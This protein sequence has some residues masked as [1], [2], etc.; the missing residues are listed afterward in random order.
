MTCPTPLRI[1]KCLAHSKPSTPKFDIKWSFCY[2]RYLDSY[3]K[4]FKMYKANGYLFRSVEALGE[5]L[6]IHSGKDIVVTYV[7][8][9]F[10]GDPMEQ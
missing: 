7:T 1:G 2:N 9:Y 8:E 6:K 10:L 4:D 5:Y 3:I